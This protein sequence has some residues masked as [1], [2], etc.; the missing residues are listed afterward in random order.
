[1]HKVSYRAGNVQA[2]PNKWV[3]LTDQASVALA[4]LGGRWVL[5]ILAA[6]GT[7][8]RPMRY[9]ELRRDIPGVSGRV[10]AD[11]LGALCQASLVIRRV[12]DGRPI[13]ITYELSARG[14]ALTP[15]LRLLVAWAADPSDGMRRDRPA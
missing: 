12:R 4:T 6:L 10:L 13:L 1:M 2:G 8:N 3:G 9:S 11:R 15:A 7:A 5:H 14:Q